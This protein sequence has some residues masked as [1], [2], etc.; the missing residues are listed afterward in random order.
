MP[1]ST[2]ERKQETITVWNVCECGEIL[3]SMNEGQRG[4]CSRCWMDSMSSDTKHAMAKLFGAAFRK[5]PIS[6]DE[7]DRLID[8]AMK[9]LD[10]DR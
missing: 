8:D 2:I 1:K 7:K 3:F 4:T 10:R 5:V 6:D 9:K